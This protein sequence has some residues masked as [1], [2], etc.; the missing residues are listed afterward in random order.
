MFAVDRCP[1]PPQRHGN[2]LA[3]T[4]R[5]PVHDCRDLLLAR[6]TLKTS[7]PTKLSAVPRAAAEE[8]G[9]GSKKVPGC[10]PDVQ[11]HRAGGSG[12]EHG[13]RGERLE[14]GVNRNQGVDE[15]SGSQKQGLTHLQVTLHEMRD[16]FHA[17]GH[18]PPPD[19]RGTRTRPQP[20]LAINPDR[21]AGSEDASIAAAK[22]VLAESQS[23]T[24]ALAVA[25]AAHAA[26][27]CD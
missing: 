25:N 12:V 17:Q 14:V 4:G 15:H 9:R 22:F 2:S 20:A 19:R 16:G 8:S 10:R 6:A 18:E 24:S 3:K 26:G 21:S 1:Q 5:P 11:V 23:P 13:L 7:P 27:V